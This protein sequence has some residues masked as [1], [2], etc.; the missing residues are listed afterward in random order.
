MASLTQ[1][2]EQL[3]EQQRILAEKIKEDEIRKHKAG[4]NI[5]RLEALNTDQKEG[6]KQY[7][8]S[9]GKYRGVLEM[10]QNELEEKIKKAG[11][12]WIDEA[13]VWAL[14]NASTLL[15]LRDFH[16]STICVNTPK[17]EINE[18]RVCG[19]EYKEYQTDRGHKLLSIYIRYLGICNKDCWNNI[20]QKYKDLIMFRGA[21]LGDDRK[22]AKIP[23]PKEHLIN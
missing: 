12:K 16:G 13:K 10:Q 4:L 14:V 21:I 18:C 5:K 23:V 19:N 11:G 1:Q 3:Q 8:S 20:Q 15:P 17:I 7:T 22:R 9:R 2:M 6:I